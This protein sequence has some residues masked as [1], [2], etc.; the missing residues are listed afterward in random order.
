M[1]IVFVKIIELVAVNVLPVAVDLLVR[2][3]RKKVREYEKENPAVI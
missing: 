2:F 3:L 1:K